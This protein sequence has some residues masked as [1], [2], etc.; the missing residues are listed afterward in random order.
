VKNKIQPDF[1]EFC[2]LAKKGN[3]VPVYMETLADLLT[4]VSA[5]INVSHKSRYSFLL[6]SVEGGERAARYSFIG[7][8]PYSIFKSKGE[9][10]EVDGAKFHG[11]PLGAIERIFGGFKVAGA[12]ALPPFIGG[13][14]G[15]FAYDIIRHIEKL[16]D[17]TLDDLGFPDI[18]LMFT[19]SILIFDHLQHTIKIVC[20]ARIEEGRPLREIYREAE[21]KIENLYTDLMSARFMKKEK[22]APGKKPAPVRFRTN[23][24]RNEYKKMVLA[25]KEYI[26]AGDIF[27]V[28]LS[29]RFSAKVD[30]PPFDIY[31]A[32]RS[33]N[34]S[35]YMFYL[36]LDDIVLVGASPEVLVTVRGRDITVRPIAGTR[37]RPEDRSRESAV[38]ADLL[39]DE[40]ERAEHIMLVDLGR[41]DVGRIAEPG[42]VAVTEL[43][44]I[45]KYSHV[46]HIVSNVAGKLR[47]GRNAIDAL[48]ACFPAGTV[49]GAPKVRAMEIIDELEPTRRGPYAG[50]IGYLSYTGFFDTCITIRTIFIKDGVAHVQAGGGIVADSSPD[51]EYQESMNKAMALRLAIERAAGGIT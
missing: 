14:V 3:I 51:G 8:A 34:P 41:N 33:M 40:K 50:A 24:T 36:N 17:K 49:S 29:Q 13:G 27:Q 47:R 25:A 2:R 46:I 45:E 20:C 35:P 21:A 18:S 1:Q 23:V 43:M 4:P 22:P 31:R 32:L 5:Y 37:R 6:E 15:F 48:R 7:V 26:R 11:D 10:Y 16:P 30:S 9:G 12:E 42:S 38:I 19:D 28:V 39:S 44:F